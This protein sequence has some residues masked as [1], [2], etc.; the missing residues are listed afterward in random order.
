MA[1]ILITGSNGQL[2]N[3][4]RNIWADGAP[5][6][7]IKKNANKLF[8]TDVSELDITD[9]GAVERFVSKEKIE[10]IV[11]CAAYTAVDNY[12]NFFL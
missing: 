2:G 3:E 4:M 7:E 11:N 5:G 10:I 1:N 8:F 6:M 12:L 9:R